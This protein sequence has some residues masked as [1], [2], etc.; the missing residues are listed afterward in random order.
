MQTAHWRTLGKV[1]FSILLVVVLA[2]LFNVPKFFEYTPITLASEQFNYT[3]V[4]VGGTYLRNDIVYRYLYNTALYCLTIYLL[5]LSVLTVLNFR[6]VQDMRKAR[7]QWEQLNRNRQR[8]LK[9]TVLPLCIVL[10]FFICQTQSLAGFI[11]DAIY[12]KQEKWLSVYTAILNLL[13][14]LNSAIN[15][16]LMY[17]FGRKF[18]SL[19][20]DTFT[21]EKTLQS[22]SIK[23]RF[24]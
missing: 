5:P 8:E 6:I 15:F 7:K 10:V 18:R 3:Y 17:I 4:D 23:E 20:K 16:L 19:L 14:M 1:R 13:V 22:P 21:C 24:V 9:A 11:L 2:V 12:V